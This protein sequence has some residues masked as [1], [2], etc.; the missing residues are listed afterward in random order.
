MINCL[1]V[2]FVAVVSGVLTGQAG[3]AD[4][5]SGWKQSGTISAV[6]ARQAAA[7]DHEFVYAIDNKV[8]VKYNRRTGERLA[9]S[10]GD[11]LHLN[12]G[13]FHNGK[14]YCA[15]SNY[16]MKPEQSIVKVLDV[17]TMELTDA[18]D[19]GDSQHGSLTVVL[20]HQDAWWCVFA[21]YGD[22]NQKTVLVKYTPSWKESGV[23]TFPES[24]VSRLGKYSISGGVWKDSMLLTTGHDDPVLFRLQLPQEGCVLTHVD[25]VDAPFTGQGIAVD[26]VT[27]G[28]VGINRK[29]RQVIFAISDMLK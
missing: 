9:E 7:A 18:K 29:N 24:V 28:L 13:F 16:P 14:M 15:H 11:A 27:G 22:E 25:S 20:F 19:F 6:E 10:T 4:Q 5:T 12:S 26:P 23:W 21:R 2:L 1:I 17:Q 3:A 8:V